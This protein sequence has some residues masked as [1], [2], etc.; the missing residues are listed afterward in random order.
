MRRVTMNSATSS[1]ERWR[2]C[3]RGAG[4]ACDVAPGGATREEVV[5][6][7]VAA[8]VLWPLVDYGPSCRSC[9][10]PRRRRLDPVRAECRGCRELAGRY[11]GALADLH[12]VTYTTP[13]GALCAAVRD[14]K[15]R[16]G[17]RSDTRLACDIGAILSAY[18]E[19]QLQ[20]GL[21]GRPRF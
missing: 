2:E 8:S 20:G 14:L 17:A 4:C 13:D 7:L 15:D 3:R 6:R 12:P 21:L 19:A 18:L 16:L 11:E 10:A 9:A 1:R 5:E